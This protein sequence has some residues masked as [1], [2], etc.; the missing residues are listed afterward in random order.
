MSDSQFG[1][2]TEREA[3]E[4]MGLPVPAPTPLDAMTQ[5]IADA[6]QTSDAAHW[7]EAVARAL[8]EAGYQKVEK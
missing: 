5:I 2:Y 1:G 6:A 7:P 8:I 3:H 4:I